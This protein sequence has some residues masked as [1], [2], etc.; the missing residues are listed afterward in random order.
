MIK[1]ILGISIT[2]NVISIIIFIIIYRYSIKGLKNKLENYALDN[3]MDLY[4]DI[5]KIRKK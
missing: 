3:F 5:E 4:F 2:F 1:F